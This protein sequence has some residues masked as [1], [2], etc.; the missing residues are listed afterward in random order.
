[1]NKKALIVIALA[2]SVLIAVPAFS[3][4][5]ANQKPKIILKIDVWLNTP[6]EDSG[7]VKIVGDHVLH[8]GTMWDGAATMTVL[9][10]LPNPYPDSE[11]IIPGSDPPEYFYKGHTHLPAPSVMPFPITHMYMAGS[12]EA[13]SHG[14]RER[15]TNAGKWHMEFT[16]TLG[17]IEGEPFGWQIKHTCQGVA[18]VH[19]ASWSGQGFG[20]L[21]GVKASGVSIAN[22]MEQGPAARP[23]TVHKLLEGV[24]T[25]GHDKFPA[26]LTPTGPS[27]EDMYPPY[28]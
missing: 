14:E 23:G 28:P 2:L 7:N 12:F 9:Q 27:W 15:Y 4:V 1:M 17:E 5:A 20:I 24:V 25:S 22:M 18:I 3:A 6:A 11:A 8:E 21:E 13:T 19:A 10:F 16:I 26:R